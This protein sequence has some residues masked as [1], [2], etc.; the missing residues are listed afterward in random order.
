MLSAPGSLQ[1]CFQAILLLAL[2]VFLLAIFLNVDIRLLMS[3]LGDKAEGP[4]I[5][6]VMFLKTHKTASSTVLNIL[7]RFAETNNLSVALPVG[8][9]FHLGYPWLF[10]ARYVEGVEPSGPKQHFN[11]M[12]NHLRF[13]L[14]E[15]QKVMP[16]DTFYF[17]ILRNP[18]FQLESSFVYYKDHTPAFRGVTSLEA[19]LASPWTYYNWSLGLS[20]I[21]ARNNMWF[22]LGFDNN[23]PAE[24]G[25]VRAS[26]AAVEQRFQLVL[27]AEH[28][29]ES[30]VLL[31]RLLRWRLDDVVS[32]SLNSRS[33]RTVT[34][35]TPEGQE[36]AQRW[37]ALDWRL[38]Q[39][40]NRTFWAKVHAELG[41]QRLRAEVEL[42]R[43]RRR[44]LEALCLQDGGPKNQ[45]QI[46]DR[47]LRPYQSGKADIL[48]YNL[49][50]GLD[51]QTLQMC[52]R[53]V[54]PE[55]QYMAHLYTLQFPEKPPKKIPFLEE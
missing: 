13:N 24:E 6:N 36:R 19:F 51:N 27:I 20:N 46:T 1:R 16:K 40:F 21:Y 31:R 30:M 8:S 15:V 14:P 28:F 55:L 33:R 39:H 3:F 22:D 48:G 38:Y 41:L 37:C 7:F 32:F 23:A 35:L 2:T 5:T 52:R 9:Q 34:S 45:L 44:E 49:R 29:D 25:Y 11:I 43:V 18:V 4:P 50:L 17:S 12:C 26:L 42:L 47:L 10:L 53:M 54:M